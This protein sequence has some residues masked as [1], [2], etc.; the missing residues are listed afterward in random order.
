[1]ALSHLLY[2]VF[3]LCIAIG[4][5]L[6]FTRNHWTPLLPLE[7]QRRISHYIAIPQHSFTDDMEAGFTSS[8]FD[9]SQNVNDSDDRHGLDTEARKEVKRIMKT[10]KCT[11]DQARLIFLQD[12]M[13]RAG[14]DPMTGL[15]TDRKFVSFG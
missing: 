2:T 3:L 8:E 6:Y 14:I 10:K 4:S 13:R 1:M 9:L 15:P 5:L 12:K 11:F 7:I